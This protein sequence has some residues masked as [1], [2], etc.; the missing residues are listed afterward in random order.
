[1]YGKTMENL[2]KR[3]KIRIVKNEK[4][5]VKHISKLSYVSHKIFDKHLVAIHEKK[6]C[7]T[8]NKQTYICLINSIRNK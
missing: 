1:M 6:I 5:M 2:S 8:L 3:I 7:L 4:D